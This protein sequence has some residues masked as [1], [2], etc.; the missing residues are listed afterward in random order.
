MNPILGETLQG[1]YGDGTRVYCEQI[2]HHPPISSILVVGAEDSYRYYG[3]YQFEA[4]AGLNSMTLT[5]KGHRVLE[6]SD[7]GRIRANF[8]KDTFSG[9]FLGSMRSEVVGDIEFVDDKNDVRCSI[10]FGKVKNKY[11]CC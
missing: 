4:K 7:G 10:T 3:H 5:N 1:A 9:V 2:S 6:F 8:S 11:V